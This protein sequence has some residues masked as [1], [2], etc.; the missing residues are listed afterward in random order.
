MIENL[1]R[2][3]PK[4]RSCRLYKT[5]Y[6]SNQENGN[7]GYGAMR[8]SLQK[9][10][11]SVLCCEIHHLLTI[12]QFHFDDISEDGWAPIKVIPLSA[13]EI[14]EEAQKTIDSAPSGVDY[15]Y[16]AAC[17]GPPYHTSE[18]Q[19]GQDHGILCIQDRLSEAS[20]RLRGYRSQHWLKECL[21]T[22]KRAQARQFLKQGLLQKSFV[23]Q[24]G[25]VSIT[26]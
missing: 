13:E 19:V 20:I 21:Q 10:S 17:R 2:R 5:G 4:F 22:P 7:G 9:K 11:R 15:D 14:R 24:H 25:D 26:S 8:Y 23:Y 16:E 6:I 3:G 18:C 1:R 12:I